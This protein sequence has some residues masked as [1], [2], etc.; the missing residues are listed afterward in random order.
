M[1]PKKIDS[2]AR[3]EQIMTAATAVFAR[4]G[5][6]G[7]S[8]DD[9]VQASGLSKGGLYWH[10]D[11]KDAIIDAILSQF[12]DREMADLHR[13]AGL[14][15]PA[16]ERLR[17]LGDTIAA[18]MAGIVEL[19]SLSL[20]FYALA[21]RRSETRQFLRDYFQRYGALLLTIIQEGIDAGDFVAIEATTAAT[22]LISQFEGIA[23]LWAIDPE[24]IDLAQQSRTAV[25]LLLQGLLVRP[26]VEK[27]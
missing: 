25:Y 21:A 26:I 24:L 5:F 9:I 8:M 15:L 14:D 12:F 17:L 3:R 11:S 16:A 6:D 22:A 7:T 1:S 20:E 18:E 10:F 27:R 4:K 23:L 2:Y 13:L 19:A